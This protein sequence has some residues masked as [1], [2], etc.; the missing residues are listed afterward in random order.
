MTYAPDAALSARLNAD[1]VTTDREL[2]DRTSGH[3]RART[4]ADG[5]AA[6]AMSP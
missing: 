6:C 5:L 2:L 4:P 1:L 3:L